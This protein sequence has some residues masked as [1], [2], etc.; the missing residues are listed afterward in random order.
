MGAVGDVNVSG[1]L[2]TFGGIILTALLG[3]VGTI[4]ARRIRGQR[5]SEPEM[6]KRLDELSFIV[7]GGR[8]DEG[9]EQLGLLRRMEITE[10]RDRVKG[11]I[12]RSLVRQWPSDHVPRL[13]PGYLDDLDEDTL[14]LDHPWRVKPSG[15]GPVAQSRA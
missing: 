2:F 5:A 8:D 3:W 1:L 14:P 6:W 12:I 10:R 13:D 15:T 9:N 7:Y 4:I 11:Y